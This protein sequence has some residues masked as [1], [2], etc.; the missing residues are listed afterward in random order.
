MIQSRSA[1]LLGFLVA[2]SAWSGEPL[3]LEGYLKDVRSKN[4]AV[5]GAFLASEGSEQRSKEAELSTATALFAD[6]EFNSDGKLPVIALT[7]WDRIEMQ[8]YTLGLKK[9]TTFGMEAKLYYLMLHTKY[10]NMTSPFGGI[11]APDF[12]DVRPTLELT[13]QLWAGG[14]GRT[15]RARQEQAEAADLANSFR[16]RH[17]G[18]VLMSGAEEAF[19]NLSLAREREEVTRLAMEQAKKIYSWNAERVRRSLADEVDALQAK[20]AL[21]LSEMEHQAA[22]DAQRQASRTVNKFRGIVSDEVPS[23]MPPLKSEQLLSQAVPDIKPDRDDVKAAEQQQRAAIAGA[24]IAKEGYR[25]NLEV[26]GLYGLNGRDAALGLGIGNSFQAGRPTYTV[27]LRFNMPLDRSLASAAM[28]GVAKEQM[29]AQ[30]QYQQKL[31]D[32][33]QDWQDLGQRV[34]ELKNRLKLCQS[35]SA[36]QKTK[37]DRERKRLQTG[38]TTTFQVLS[39]EQD[40]ARSRLNE[41]NAKLELVRALTQ[42]KLFGENT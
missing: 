5:A 15:T 37:L 10:V 27:G 6:A 18:R 8:K 25:P 9:L 32:Q 16:S 39:F 36:T 11:T 38:R 3:S 31:K 30:M 41:I 28:A 12:F 19:W 29:A 24:V 23:E 7:S 20:A 33:L 17:E 13:Q 40:Y 14:F 34:A 21:E 42:I 35:I 2:G 1:V 22:V 26:Y 4:E